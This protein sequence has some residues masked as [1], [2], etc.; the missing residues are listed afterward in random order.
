MQIVTCLSESPRRAC[1]DACRLAL[2]RD[3]TNNTDTRQ[4]RSKT[5]TNRTKSRQTQSASP[6]AATI[7][8]KIDGDITIAL[9]EDS[10]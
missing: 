1:I 8:N 4:G 10:E 3:Q 9:H 7:A 5:K 2:V 6:V